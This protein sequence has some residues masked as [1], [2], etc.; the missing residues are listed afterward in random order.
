MKIFNLKGILTHIFQLENCSRSYCDLQKI[1]INCS[2]LSNNILAS[3]CKPIMLLEKS[4]N[5]D[6]SHLKLVWQ[7]IIFICSTKQQKQLCGLNSL[8]ENN[9]K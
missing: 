5:T 6:A 9:A 7:R 1:S 3:V 8:L 2:A 4:Q